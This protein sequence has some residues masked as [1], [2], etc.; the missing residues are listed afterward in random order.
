MSYGKQS[1]R[2]PHRSVCRRS[3]NFAGRNPPS[4]LSS[5]QV[6]AAA[7]PAK[8]AGE[9]C[10]N[11]YLRCK[12][13]PRQ[14]DKQKCE[15]D[16]TSCVAKKCDIKVSGAI[17]QC[18]KDPD[19]ESSCTEYARS[20]SGLRSCCFG[21]PTHN[22]SCRKLV[23]TTCNPG[24]PSSY[25]LL[26]GPVFNESTGKWEGG[27][28]EDPGVNAAP[29]RQGSPGL[30]GP[31]TIWN[32][33]GQ[34]VEPQLTEKP[35]LPMQEFQRPPSANNFFNGTQP[36]LPTEYQPSQPYQAP[37]SANQQ[38]EA[39]AYNNNSYLSTQNASPP[40]GMNDNKFST[41]VMAP[42]SNSIDTNFR[43]TPN[44]LSV[45]SPSSQSFSVPSNTFS[46][47]PISAQADT[48]V[49]TPTQPQSA[50]QQFWGRF[51]SMFKF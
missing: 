25:F 22:V 34:L 14:T 32:D 3:R 31:G 33:Q 28:P 5:A 21:G 23:D 13:D 43:A 6:G 30:L 51:T 11:A 10:Q 4:D 26:A 24:T 12:Y 8:L 39:L 15:T 44:T 48:I 35:Q 17:K 38:I 36:L 19:C 16:W 37:P 7:T 50:F 29:L 18:A 46:Q 20:T 41:D 40:S 2:R 1:V 9:T 49:V 42:P 45:V 47:T 27:E